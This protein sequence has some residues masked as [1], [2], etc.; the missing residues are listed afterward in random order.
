ML[1]QKCQ[2]VLG[3]LITT[4]RKG[5][6]IAS[7]AYLARKYLCWLVLSEPLSG[8]TQSWIKYHISEIVE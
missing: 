3:S 7:I 4:T 8:V 1:P 2:W 6:E 5:A